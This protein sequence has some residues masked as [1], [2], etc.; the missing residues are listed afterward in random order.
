MTRPSAEERFWAKVDKSGECWNWTAYKMP[1][2]Y[3]QFSFLRRV[4]LAHRVAYEFAYGAPPSGMD[5]DHKC[6]NRGCV[7]PAHLQAVSRS[8]NNQNRSGAQRN[9]QSGI[10][11]VTWDSTTKNWRVIM[12]ADGK[13]KHIGRYPDIAI[14]EG[15]ARAYRSENYPNSLVDKGSS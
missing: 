5:V 2:G 1:N 15:V 3:G 4:R 11:G 9:S 12:T 8:L 13:R 7:N 10:R 14:A 6:R